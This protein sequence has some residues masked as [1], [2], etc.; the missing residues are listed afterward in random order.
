MLRILISLFVFYI[1]L[2]GNVYARQNQ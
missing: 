2:N 1:D